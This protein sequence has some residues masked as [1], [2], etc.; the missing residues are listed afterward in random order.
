MNF[1]FFLSKSSVLQLYSKKYWVESFVGMEEHV[2]VYLDDIIIHSSAETHL[3]IIEEVL[4]RLEEANL[5]VNES[6][7]AFGRRKNLRLN[8]LVI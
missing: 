2:S 4:K 1:V 6:K 7:C 3:K 8:I 5:V